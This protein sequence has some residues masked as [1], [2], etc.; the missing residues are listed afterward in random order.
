MQ[1]PTVG[2]TRANGAVG[3]KHPIEAELWTNL[4]T[5]GDGF[6]ELGS[7]ALRQRRGH[8]HALAGTPVAKG[9]LNLAD[10]IRIEAMF[11]WL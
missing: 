2:P 3:Q 1:E 7:R 5:V 10:F 6:R 4:S 9:K 8:R 11:F